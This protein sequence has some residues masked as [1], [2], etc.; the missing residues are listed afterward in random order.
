MYLEHFGFEQLPFHLTP[1]TSLFLGLAPHYEA[2][3]TVSAAIDL[4]EGVIKITGEVGTGKTMVCRMLINYLHNHIAL[5]YL[6][7][8]ALNG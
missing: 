5:I 1:N 8:P 7:N 3:Q 4:G 6:P 2:I